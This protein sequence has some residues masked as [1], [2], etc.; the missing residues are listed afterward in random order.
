MHPE[1]ALRLLALNRTF[2]QTLAGPFAETRRRLQPGVLRAAENLPS[3]A[4]VLDL[5]CAHGALAHEL[6]RRGHQG[7][8]VGLDSSPTLLALASEAP[9]PPGAKFRLAE[10]AQSGW[11]KDLTG[12]FDRVFAFAVL[13]HLPGDAIRVSLLREIHSLLSTDGRFVHSNWNFLESERLRAR[14]TPWEAVALS[15]EEVDPDD[16]L[17]DWRRGGR[18]LR[19]VHRFTPLDLSALAAQ[20]GFKVELTYESDGENN[21]LGHYE[22]WLKA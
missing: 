19:Y 22:V 14:I 2:Y 11:S 7:R 1:I 9:V 16:Y 15:P 10:L 8:Y 4:S 17:L 12:P 5:G 13:H 20:T 21:R 18:G 3:D 6:A